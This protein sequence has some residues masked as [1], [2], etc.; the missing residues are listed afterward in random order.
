MI[1]REPV[2]GDHGFAV[3]RMDMEGGKLR[4]GDG[5]CDPRG[6][7]EL[8]RRIKVTENS[9]W[10]PILFPDQPDE[11]RKVGSGKMFE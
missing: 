10:T 3:R 11:N 6:P 1:R 9:V 5:V 8:G 4:A 7:S 2:D